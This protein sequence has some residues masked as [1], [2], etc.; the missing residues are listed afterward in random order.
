MSDNSFI[1]KINNL[2]NKDLNS[3]INSC[4]II[5]KINKLKLEQTNITF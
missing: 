5:N 3:I 4:K 1:E 2:I